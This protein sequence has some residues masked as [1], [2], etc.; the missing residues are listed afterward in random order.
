MMSRLFSCLVRLCLRITQALLWLLLFVGLALQFSIRDS[1]D[2]LAVVFYMLPLP[3]L[4]C[5]ALAL[6]WWQ[7]DRPRCSR[8]ASALA[9]LIGLTWTTR[10]WCWNTAPA[11]SERLPQEVRVL[12]WNLGRPGKPG[13]DLVD[14]VNAFQP[15]LIGCT[16]PMARNHKPDVAAWQKAFPAYQVR[17]PHQEL[18]W[19]TRGEPQT[20]R[21]GR[22]D[23]IGSYARL[24]LLLN[25][26]SVPV[27]VADVWASPELPRTRQ[28]RELLALVTE[29]SNVLLLGDFNT[30]G[31]S[32]HFDAFRRELTD[33]FEEAGRGLRET[34]FYGLPVLSLDHLWVGKDWQ[35]IDARKVWSASSDHAALLIRLLPRDNATTSPPTAPAAGG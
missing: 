23:G 8:F 2:A 5:F 25:N 18:L 34:W 32:A 27:V 20:E 24:D 29:R 28:L 15:D 10:S 3:L 7:Y 22:L 31:E 9:V 11:Q 35:V 30:P 19:M 13:A 4:L 26:Q 1:V 33:A 16:E 17:P 21:V 14:L 12:F 6:A